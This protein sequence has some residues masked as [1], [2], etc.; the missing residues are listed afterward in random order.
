MCSMEK[1]L[2]IHLKELREQIAQDIQSL[3]IEASVE[4]A[5]GIQIMAAKIAR[6]EYVNR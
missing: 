1:T 5:A 2:E 3:K 6:G 4:N